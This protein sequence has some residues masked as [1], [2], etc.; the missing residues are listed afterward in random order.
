MKVDPL[1]L[2]AAHWAVEFAQA[3]GAVAGAGVAAGAGGAA[4]GVGDVPAPMAAQVPAW[5]LTLQA[6]QVG[7]AR[8]CRSRRRRCSC[9]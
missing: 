4:A 8:R 1:Q 3:P 9:R 6:W 5:P 7:A 2:A